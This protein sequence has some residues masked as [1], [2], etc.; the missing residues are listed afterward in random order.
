MCLP[1]CFLHGKGEPDEGIFGMWEDR[2]HPRGARRGEGRGVEYEE[3]EVKQ[4]L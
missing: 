1:Y 2:F 3:V 4:T